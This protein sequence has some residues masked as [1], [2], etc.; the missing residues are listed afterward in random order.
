VRPAPERVPADEDARQRNASVRV[1]RIDDA[2][3]E[4]VTCEVLEFARQIEGFDCPVGVLAAARTELGR[5]ADPVAKQFS[6]ELF[7]V[8]DA[9]RWIR[10]A[11]EG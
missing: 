7:R 9:A 8:H 5:N 6:L 1:G 11:H 10:R 2:K 3:V 4:A